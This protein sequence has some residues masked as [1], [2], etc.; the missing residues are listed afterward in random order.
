MTATTTNTADM[1]RA[2]EAEPDLEA[3]DRLVDALCALVRPD[4]RLCAGC[5]WEGIVKPLAS[6][7]VGWERGAP[8]TAST[9]ADTLGLRPVGDIAAEVDLADQLRAQIIHGDQILGVPHAPEPANDTERWLRSHEAWDAVTN[10]WL[11]RLEAAD[12]G[13]GHGIGRCE[14]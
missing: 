7:L 5:T 3:L 4:D 8:R 6:A 12:P 2:L 11:A 10:V 14:A 9:P 1:A 13:T